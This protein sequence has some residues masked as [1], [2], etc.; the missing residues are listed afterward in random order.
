[1]AKILVDITKKRGKTFNGRS[2][3]KCPKCGKRGIFE[4]HYIQDHYIHSYTVDK[5]GVFN[6]IKDEKLCMIVVPERKCA[7]DLITG[8]L[9]DNHLSEDERIL[10][11]KDPSTAPK[12]ILA[13][14]IARENQ[15]IKKAKGLKLQYEVALEDLRF[16]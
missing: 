2:I 13:K 11:M 7:N 4:K 9:K 3:K 15:R 14:R 6:L 12:Q 10:I 16:G 5:L 8:I 1:M